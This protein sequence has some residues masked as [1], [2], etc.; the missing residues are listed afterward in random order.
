MNAAELFQQDEVWQTRDGRVL[1][2]DEMT[3][4]HRANVLAMLER[5]AETLKGIVGFQWALRAAST[6]TR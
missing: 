3:S 4:D 6:A 2:L 1:S 5:K